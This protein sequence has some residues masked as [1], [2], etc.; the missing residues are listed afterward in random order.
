[1]NL[2]CFSFIT[3]MSLGIKFYTGDDL[4]E[5]DRFAMSID[6]FIINITYVLTEE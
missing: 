1:M 6:L 5:G 4:D 2:I 3:G